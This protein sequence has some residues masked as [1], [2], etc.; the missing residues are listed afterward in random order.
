MKPIVSAM[1]AW[2][3]VVISV[4][5]IVILSVLGSLYGSNNH[6]VMGSEEDPEDGPAVAASL[7]TAVVVYAAFFVFCGFQA[8]LHLR[9]S[10]G[11][12]ISLR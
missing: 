6:T 9:D 12:A 10:R 8:W 2:S 3:C 7:Y 4:F 11:G 5:A 1:N